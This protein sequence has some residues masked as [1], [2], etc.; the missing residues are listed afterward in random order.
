MLVFF[1]RSG[2]V[3]QAQGVPFIRRG[4]AVYQA[5]GDLRK[6][7]KKPPFWPFPKPLTF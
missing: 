1:R 2:T 3:Y 6:P 7:M 5:R 4:N